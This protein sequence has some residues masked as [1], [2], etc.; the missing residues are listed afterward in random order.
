MDAHE[1]M[2][3]ERCWHPIGAGD[4]HVMRQFRDEAHPLLALLASYTHLDEDPACHAAHSSR[5]RIDH[6][7][8]AVPVIVER[9]PEPRAEES[10]PGAEHG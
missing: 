3:C 9:L 2:L 1:V 7:T 4:D 8:R 10:D 6:E 5:V